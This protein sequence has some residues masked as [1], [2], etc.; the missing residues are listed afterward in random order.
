MK[1]L[2][3]NYLILVVST[4]TQMFLKKSVEMKFAWLC[5]NGFS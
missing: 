1:K 2:N 3:L 5:M 4:L